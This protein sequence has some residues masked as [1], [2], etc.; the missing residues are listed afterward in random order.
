MG[1]YHSWIVDKDTLPPEL[2]ATSFDEEGNVTPLRHLTLPVFGTQFHPESVITD[3]GRRLLA[4]FL[5]IASGQPPL[6]P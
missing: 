6:A 3:C 1:R 5:A 2:T 4:A